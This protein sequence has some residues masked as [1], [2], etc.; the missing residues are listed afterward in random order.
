M[1]LWLRRT[2]RKKLRVELGKQVKAKLRPLRKDRACVSFRCGTQVMCVF[3]YLLARYM[4]PEGP[5]QRLAAALADSSAFS[6][7]L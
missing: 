1:Q 6:H 4:R 3:L 2:A 5:W 7:P